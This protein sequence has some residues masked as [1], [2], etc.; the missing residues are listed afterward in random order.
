MM[1]W[2]KLRIVLLAVTFGC[3]MLVLVNILQKQ[4][5]KKPKLESSTSETYVEEFQKNYFWQSLYNQRN[6]NM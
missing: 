2:S 3:V 1:I 4:I 6:G 5:G